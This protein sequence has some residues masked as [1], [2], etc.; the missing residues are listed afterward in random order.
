MP[1][2]RISVSHAV[3]L[4]FH[5]KLA[6]KNTHPQVPEISSNIQKNRKI[7]SDK[8]E[9]TYMIYIDTFCFNGK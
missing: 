6:L 7:H 1:V 8:I 2:L 4:Q 5:R 3:E 9:V